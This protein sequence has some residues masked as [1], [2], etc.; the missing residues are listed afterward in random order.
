ME[1]RKKSSTL[2]KFRNLFKLSS[3]FVFPHHF[4]D[5]LSCGVSQ[6]LIIDVSGFFLFWREKK[7]SFHFTSLSS[8]E[9]FSINIFHSFFLRS[10]PTYPIH[11]RAPVEFEFKNSALCVSDQKH[12]RKTSKR[13]GSDGRTL[14]VL[15]KIHG[16]HVFLFFAPAIINI[17]NNISREIH[18]FLLSVFSSSFVDLCV[19]ASHLFTLQKL[20][21]PPHSLSWSEYKIHSSEAF[22]KG[23]CETFSDFTIRKIR[24]LIFPRIFMYV[25]HFL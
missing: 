1:G 5:E 6:E 20:D 2:E 22:A 14:A 17:N 4:T 12:S 19:G 18:I 3:L 7:Y 11:A 15:H 21:R 10:F 24:T 16:L 23:K 13:R 8:S 25:K 9:N